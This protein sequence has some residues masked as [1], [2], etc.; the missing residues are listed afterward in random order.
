M[1]CNKLKQTSEGTR[2]LHRYLVVFIGIIIVAASQTAFAA[3]QNPFPVAEAR[4]SHGRVMKQAL[5]C[6]SPPPA[7]RDLSFDSIYEDDDPT[8]SIVDP[9]KKEDYRIG[10][11]TLNAYEN[12]LTDMANDY[13]LSQPPRIK[14]AKC[15]LRWLYKWAVQ[16]ALLGKVNSTGQSVRK[17]TLGS[18]ASAYLQIKDE[19]ALDASEKKRVE[20]W[21]SKVAYQVVEDFSADPTRRSRQN[22]HLLWAAWAVAATSA[23]VDDDTLFSWAMK[24]AQFGLSQV[25]EDGTLPLEMARARRALLYHVFSISPL[26]MMAEMGRENGVDLYGYNNHALHRLIFVTLNGLSSP[27]FFVQRTGHKQDYKSI[28]SSQGM[29]W[30]PVYMRRFD[31]PLAASWANKVPQPLYNR[32]MGGSTTLLFGR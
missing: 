15:T 4:E 6:G 10:M 1:L 26:V 28:V 8:A 30:L 31:S 12:R 5:A 23:A 24:R 21:L 20:K 25:Q 29:A 27:S 3:V 2:T 14:A 7:M 32:R 13:A 16:D 9:K 18:V 22:N 11:R 17:W 19:P